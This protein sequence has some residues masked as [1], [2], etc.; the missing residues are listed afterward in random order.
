MGTFGEKHCTE[1][2]NKGLSSVQ[3]LIGIENSLYIL[4]PACTPEF[5]VL[6]IYSDTYQL[7]IRAKF[8]A[9]VICLDC[10]F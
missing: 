5:P 7:D 10:H 9:V 8:G 4:R 3:E 1:K 6:D 2:N